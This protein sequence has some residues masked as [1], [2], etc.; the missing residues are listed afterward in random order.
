VR[1]LTRC[2]GIGVRPATKSE[3]RLTR[4]NVLS[5]LPRV[6]DASRSADVPVATKHHE[7]WEPVLPGL[8]CVRKTE[9]ER[10]FGGEEWD[11]MTT[12]DVI[13]EIRDEMTEVVLLLGANG[14]VGQKNAHALPGK[15]ADRVVHVDPGVH[16]FARAELRPRRTQLRRN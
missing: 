8:F 4:A 15:T 1:N 9:L 13:P 16:A 6:F 12:R 11:D 10:V 3:T 5:Q 14:A 7:G 2:L